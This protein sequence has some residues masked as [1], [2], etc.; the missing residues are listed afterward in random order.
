MW[1]HSETS[2]L[3]MGIDYLAAIAGEGDGRV[4]FL[5][6]LDMQKKFPNVFYP[7]Y[8]IQSEVVRTS[9]GHAWWDNKK[10]LMREKIE[11]DKALALRRLKDKAASAKKEAEAAES[12]E[13]L[14]YN[15]MGFFSYYFM[16]WRRAAM[17]IKIAKI[18]AISAQLESVA[19]SGDDKGGE[20]DNFEEGGGKGDDAKGGKKEETK[21]DNGKKEDT[22]KDDGKK[23]DNKAAA[24]A[25]A[26]AVDATATPAAKK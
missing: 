8:R 25:K 6:L 22:K 10:I 16:P 11:K 17:R 19:A 26:P 3:N 21:K 12:N 20:E 5:D 4:D 2:N 9:M 23:D 13:D 7:A 24:A 1:D 18:A 15:R 14:V